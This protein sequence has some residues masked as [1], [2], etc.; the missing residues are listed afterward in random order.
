M[1]TYIV[2]FKGTLPR[3]NDGPPPRLLEAEDKGSTRALADTL[4]ARD[5]MQVSSVR[6]Y[7]GTHYVLEQTRIDQIVDRANQFK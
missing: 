6:R 2:R 5:G 3:N 7:F 4:A 1:K